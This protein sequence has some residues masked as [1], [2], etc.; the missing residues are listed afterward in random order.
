MTLIRSPRTASVRLPPAPVSF[1]TSP[2]QVKLRDLDLGAG[3]V[4]AV[5]GYRIDAVRVGGT[6]TLH[7]PFPV[8][9]A[10]NSSSRS[11]TPTA[12]PSTQLSPT[13]STAVS[14][15]RGSCR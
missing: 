13:T 2:L 1:T 8:L 14:A 11:S 12:A 7:A 9:L 5:G 4:V 10:T 6:P 15:R 3:R